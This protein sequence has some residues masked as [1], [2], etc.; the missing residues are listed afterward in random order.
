MSMPISAN[1]DR[2]SGEKRAEVEINL[3]PICKVLLD[4]ESG[5]YEVVA[6]PASQWDETTG[7]LSGRVEARE[8][9]AFLGRETVKGR[10]P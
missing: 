8:A 6:G 4:R 5:I 2:F 10:L 9:V 1:E 7:G 3:W